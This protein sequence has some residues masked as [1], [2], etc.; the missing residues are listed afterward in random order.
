MRS[1]FLRQ[2]WR[3]FMQYITRPA[4][5]AHSNGGPTLADVTA[6]PVRTNGSIDM[7]HVPMACGRTD[8]KSVRR[9]Q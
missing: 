7:F 5:Y 1:A 9:D 8:D 2:P 3:G 4:A 6:G